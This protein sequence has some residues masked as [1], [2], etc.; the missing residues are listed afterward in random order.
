[1]HHNASSA[2][3]VRHDNGIHEFIFR[4]KSKRS[5]DEVFAWVEELN[6]SLSPDETMLEL[7]D[8]SAGLPPI[9][10]VTQRVRELQKRFP[11][12]PKM[13]V[14][15]LYQAHSVLSILAALLA[16]LPMSGL[17]V[18]QFHVKDRQAAIEWLLRRP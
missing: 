3:Y 7:V 16:L 12:L 2:A 1:M 14:A 18:R 9:N 15:F 13:R 5:A 10:Y 6:A 8:I 17:A 11:R 4:D